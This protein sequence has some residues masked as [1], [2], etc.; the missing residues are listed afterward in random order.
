MDALPV[1]GDRLLRADGILWRVV[2]V[3][4]KSV[5]YEVLGMGEQHSISL[6]HWRRLKRYGH[7]V[8]A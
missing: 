3:D 2:C 5:R 8:A 7:L 6:E 4:L 1:P